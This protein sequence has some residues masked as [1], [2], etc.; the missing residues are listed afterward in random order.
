MGQDKWYMYYDHQEK[1]F[2]V[3]RNYWSDC[4]IK[5]PHL[6]SEKIGEQIIKDYSKEL[7]I[8]WGL[9]RYENKNTNQNMLGFT[10]LG[11]RK[12]NGKRGGY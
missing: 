10:T 3:S 4:G 9:N 1:K 2:L 7:S 8:I 5:L 12:G 6:K 11:I